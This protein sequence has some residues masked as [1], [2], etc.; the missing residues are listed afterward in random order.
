MS[1]V[2]YENS[3]DD[4]ENEDVDV[5]T[6]KLSNKIFST[7][8][9]FSNLPTPKSKSLNF[10]IKIQED[11]KDSTKLFKKHQPV[12]IL[13]PSLSK[14]RTFSFLLFICWRQERKTHR[15]FQ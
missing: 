8:G 5:N 3:S 1:L 13:I 14:V 2:A 12:K 9:L 11:I 4:S 7:S 6:A 10:P 15:L